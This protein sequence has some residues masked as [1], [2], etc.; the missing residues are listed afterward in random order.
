MLAYSYDGGNPRY[1]YVKLNAVFVWQSSH[2]GTFP[3]YRGV[4]ILLVG[5]HECSLLE[6]RHFDTF[7]NPT[8]STEL[9][10]YIQQVYR[11]T[12][13]V[14]VSADEPTRLLSSALPTLAEIGANVADVQ[15]RGAFAFVA[16]KGFPAKTVLRKAVTRVESNANQPNF[17]ATVTGATYCRSM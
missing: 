16:R 12:I 1:G 11:G 8:A 7:N 15:Y 9:N 10:N 17:K 6:W 3:L 2:S 4:N 14:G 5:P 13:I